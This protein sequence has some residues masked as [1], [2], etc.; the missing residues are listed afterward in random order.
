MTDHE[1]CEKCSHPTG[2]DS[3]FGVLGRVVCETCYSG[4]ESEG[5][6]VAPRIGGAKPL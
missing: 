5:V 6:A 2:H 4:D 1:R 3:P